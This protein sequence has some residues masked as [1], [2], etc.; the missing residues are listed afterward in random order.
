MVWHDVARRG[1]RGEVLQS[2]PK[3]WGPACRLGRVAA[4]RAL[5]ARPVHALNVLDEMPWHSRALGWS[6][7]LAGLG[8]G[9]QGDQWTSLRGQRI[10][11]T[12]LT[13]IHAKSDHALQVFDKMPQALRQVLEWS[14]TPDQCLLR[15]KREW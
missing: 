11:F 5:W 10:R 6:W 3:P 15:C 4:I 13:K 9:L 7:E 8:Y 12:L 14:K 2:G 1:A